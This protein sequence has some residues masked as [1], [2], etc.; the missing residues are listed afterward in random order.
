MLLV[1]EFPC[2]N[3]PRS[4]RN[5]LACP[6]RCMQLLVRS[7]HLLS[8]HRQH[9]ICGTREPDCRDARVAP[10]ETQTLRTDGSIF[11]VLIPRCLTSTF[12]SHVALLLKELRLT[13]F[14]VPVKPSSNFTLM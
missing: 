5:L 8:C 6:G 14:T 11:G 4:L 13:L 12:T 9:F 7:L 10:F 1:T 2:R 3:Q